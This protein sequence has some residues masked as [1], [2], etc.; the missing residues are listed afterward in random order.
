MFAYCS[1]LPSSAVPNFNTINITN[2]AYTFYYCNNLTNIPNFNTSNV[3]NIMAA[4][5]DCSNLVTVPSFNMINVTNMYHTFFNCKKLSQISINN[6][7]ASCANAIN[8][9]NKSFTNIGITDATLQGYIQNAP[10]YSA[11]V[12]NGWVL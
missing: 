11:A 10:Q 12:A 1:N 3:I 5:S 7:V 9:I 6:I 2:M 4:F 8:V